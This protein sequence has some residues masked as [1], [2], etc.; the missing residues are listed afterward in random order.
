MKRTR[1]VKLRGLV[2]CV[3]CEMPWEPLADGVCKQLCPHCGR[4]KDVR[5]ARP[6]AMRPED[7]GRVRS[8]RR[9]GVERANRKVALVLIGRGKLSCVRCG[10]D[11]V[12][13]LEINHKEG[14]GSKDNRA[15]HSRFMR[16]I[17]RRRRTIDDLELLC[18]PCNAI[19]AL[20]LKHG[21]LPMRVVWEPHTQA[22]REAA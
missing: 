11:Q 7:I 18:K 13:L 2:T 1:N 12:A 20:E 8:G 6:K 22:E 4:L 10:C 16:D 9:V 17:A 14:G 19:H 21:P 3:S 5:V 15:R